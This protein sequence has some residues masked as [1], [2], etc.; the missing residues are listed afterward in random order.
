M[1]VGK[2]RLLI[3]GA[4]N[5]EAIAHRLLLPGGDQAPPIKAE[6]GRSGCLVVPAFSLACL[7]Y[8]RFDRVIEGARRAR[9]FMYV[10]REISVWG[11]VNLH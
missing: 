6:L 2:R 3:F 4:R 8:A 11:A 5:E 10:P 1:S 7:H 9:P